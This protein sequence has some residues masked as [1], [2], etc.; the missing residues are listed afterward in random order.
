MPSSIQSA[1]H[2]AGVQAARIELL[3]WLTFWVCTA[4]FIAVMIA[5]ALAVA[6]G[7]ARRPEQAQSLRL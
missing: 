3:W 4:V 1:L 5:L 6:G 7:R 2:P